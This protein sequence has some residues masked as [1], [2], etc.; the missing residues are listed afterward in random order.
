VAF[1][2]NASTAL[3]VAYHLYQGPAGAISMIPFGLLFG[4]CFA[5]TGRLWPLVVAHGFFDLAG[6]LSAA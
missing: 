3:R 4:W 6:L 1:A 5:R 2:V